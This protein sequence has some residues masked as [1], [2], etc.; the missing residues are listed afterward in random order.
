MSE[1]TEE[2]VWE[3]RP[4]NKAL[5]KKQFLHIFL[6]VLL[7]AL[8]IYLMRL[9]EVS[10][11]LAAVDILLA[12]FVLPFYLIYKYNWDLYIATTMKYK[13]TNKAVHYTW[14][15]WGNKHLSIPLN[16]IKSADLTGSK[17]SDLETIHL[18]TQSDYELP[19]M[20]F[21]DSGHRH[22]V[23]LERLNKG[24]HLNRF[25]SGNIS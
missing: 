15:E 1:V 5:W 24:K 11:A 3:Y 14:W 16:E 22:H 18:S 6:E 17:I 20:N 13:I 25:L 21:D 9:F 7:M 12:Y 2:I 8:L 19:K 10:S 23:T 4:D